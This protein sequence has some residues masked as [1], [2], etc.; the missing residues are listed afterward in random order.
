MNG[1]EEIDVSEV[2]GVELDNDGNAFVIAIGDASCAP[3][4]SLIE[5]DLEAKP[6][7]TF[8]NPFTIEAP[9]PTPPF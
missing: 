9:R 7:T 6:Y 4:A 2:Q 1:Q 3:G 5:A 8:T